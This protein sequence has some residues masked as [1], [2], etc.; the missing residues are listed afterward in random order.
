MKV[1]QNGKFSCPACAISF[2]LTEVCTCQ[3]PGLLGLLGNLTIRCEYHTRGCNEVIRLKALSEHV[4]EFA[5]VHCPFVNCKYTYGTQGRLN[6]RDL[7]RHKISCDWRLIPCAFLCGASVAVCHADAHAIQ[8]P[9]RPVLCP[10]GCSNV[11]MP[12]DSLDAHVAHFCPK[13]VVSCEVQGC[14]FSLQRGLTDEWRR[15]MSAAQGTHMDAILTQLKEKDVRIEALVQ[16]LDNERA[17]HQKVRD[18]KDAELNTL[19]KMMH[20]ARAEVE[21]RLR[22]ANQQLAEQA[23]LLS[24]YHVCPS[25]ASS[26]ASRLPDDEVSVVTNS[27]SRDSLPSPPL[28]R[29][30]CPLWASL[31]NMPVCRHGCAAAFTDPG[32]I[33]VAGGFND[34]TA[35]DS[36]CCLRLATSRWEVLPPMP[37][38]RSWCSAAFGFDRLF[39]VGGCDTLGHCLNTVDMLDVKTLQWCRLP[40][41]MAA[42]EGS[43]AVMAGCRLVVLGGYD[44]SDH[45]PSA[46]LFDLATLSWSPLPRMDV[47]R[48]ACGACCVN[49]KV[50]VLGG[51]DGK[52]AVASVSML[53]LDQANPAWVSL[54]PM[55]F[56]RIGAATVYDE[57]NNRIVVAGGSDG[58]R[59]LSEVETLDLATMTWGLLPPMQ[60]IR[61]GCASACAD[62]RIVVLG[63]SESVTRRLSSVE[64]LECL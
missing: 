31:P 40:P 7:E 61:M 58:Q 16:L 53:D 1:G 8:C 5:P 63:G 55:V 2:P 27:P 13:T 19:R 24:K 21:G 51:S 47:P 11:E 60:F 29:K 17:E 39:V 37:V 45:L 54:S 41:M 32:T 18:A 35:L 49:G 33:V 6:R 52:S 14:G 9:H 64:M 28:K 57:R 56:P 4:C 22:A 26:C 36:V 3:D 30:R 42:R 12:F 23:L 44:G 38:A 25:S 15:H 10:N 62:G 20:N 34:E 59:Y 50:F 48:G 46:E 43:A